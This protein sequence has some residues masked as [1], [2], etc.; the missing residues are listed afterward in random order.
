MN[1]TYASLASSLKYPNS[2]DKNSKKIA[3]HKH[4]VFS[5]ERV[6]LDQIAEACALKEE[7][8]FIKRHPL[9][10]LMEAADSICYLVMDI[11]DAINKHWIQVEDVISYLNEKGVDEVEVKSREKI[12]NLTEA[13]KRMDLRKNLMDYLV[14]KAFDNFVNNIVDI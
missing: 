4:G 10:F 6:Y 2:K 11:E 8:G 14:R 13:K 5:T 7:N 1:L 3:L 9:A 12:V